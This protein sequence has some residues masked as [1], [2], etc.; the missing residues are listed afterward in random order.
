MAGRL[1][2]AAVA[3]G[4]AVAVV[5]AGA[6]VPP[7]PALSPASVARSRETV[8]GRRRASLA[9]RGKPVAMKVTG[10]LSLSR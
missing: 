6:V 4:A 5:A 8:R 9:A 2:V 7:A 1:P 10:S 3:A